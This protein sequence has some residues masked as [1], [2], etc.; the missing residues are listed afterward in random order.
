MFDFLGKLFATESPVLGELKDWA[1]S[2]SQ[3]ALIRWSAVILSGI[4]CT[5]SHACNRPAIGACLCCKKPTCLEHSFISGDA[6]AICFACVRQAAPQANPHRAAP[7]PSPR[8]DQQENEMR[9][10]F[11]RVLG[12]KER[13]GGVPD[14]EVRAAFKKLAAKHHPDRMRDPAKREAAERKFKELNAAF[15]WL[16]KEK[17]AA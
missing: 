10:K 15:Q 6:H 14:E 9:K 2:L 12:L 13:P 5:F 17:K 7:P 4:P 11:L 3:Q 1:T 8:A 16:T